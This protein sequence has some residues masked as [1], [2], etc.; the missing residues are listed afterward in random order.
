MVHRIVT[1]SMRLRMSF[2]GE[3]ANR[4]VP[5]HGSGNRCAVKPTTKTDPWL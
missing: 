3:K 2:P 4:I 1:S 5:I